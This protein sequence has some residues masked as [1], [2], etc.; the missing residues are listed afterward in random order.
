M[1]TMKFHNGSSAYV[2]VDDPVIVHAR[3]VIHELKSNGE[4]ELIMV[5]YF[6]NDTTLQLPN[7]YTL[8]SIN[9]NNGFEVLNGSKVGYNGTTTLFGDSDWADGEMVVVASCGTRFLEGQKEVSTGER[10]PAPSGFQEVFHV[11]ASGNTYLGETKNANYFYDLSTSVLLK[12]SGSPCDYFLLGLMNIDWLWGGV[13]LIETDF[14]L[15]IPIGPYPSPSYSNPIWITIPVV[16]IF[17]FIALYGVRRSRNARIRIAKN[18][19]GP[20]GPRKRKRK[21][22]IF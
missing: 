3:I 12:I 15:G 13:K 5:R 1:N 4:I 20:S 10:Q 2:D 16:S 8:V 11:F 21:K 22:K 18:D 6:S 7:L 9:G 17:L 19:R 14:D